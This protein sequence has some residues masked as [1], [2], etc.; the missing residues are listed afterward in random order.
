MAW[1]SRLTLAPQ[2]PQ[3][4]FVNDAANPAGTANPVADPPLL[5]EVPVFLGDWLSLSADGAGFPPDPVAED[6]T[7]VEPLVGK[8]ID[9]FEVGESVVELVVVLVVDVV[10]GRDFSVRLLPDDAVLEPKSSS[11]VS[12]KV[13]F[14]SDMTPVRSLGFWSSFTHASIIGAL[15]S[16]DK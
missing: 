4:L 15:Q 11:E 12:S 3:T 13:S 1:P 6:A 8:G 10:S 7:P 14:S 16:Q 2:F 5:G 9:E